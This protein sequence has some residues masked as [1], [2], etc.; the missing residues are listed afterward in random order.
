MQLLSIQ[1]FLILIFNC[2]SLQEGQYILQG[3]FQTLILLHKFCRN[4]LQLYLYK[5][6]RE[7]ISQKP[8]ASVKKL[9]LIIC[10]IKR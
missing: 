3:L 4:V 5:L 6:K 9:V 8:D 7:L 2:C 10:D 1:V